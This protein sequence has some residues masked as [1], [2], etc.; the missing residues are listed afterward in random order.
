VQARLDR[1]I[2]SAQAVRF[3]DQ[4]FAGPQHGSQS[5]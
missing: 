4:I 1:T 2:L 5:R 3:Y